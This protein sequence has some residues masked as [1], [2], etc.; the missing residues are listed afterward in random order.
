MAALAASS[1]THHLISLLD[2]LELE[3][4]AADELLPVL[5]DLLQEV[6]KLGTAFDDWSG[7]ASCLKWQAKLREMNAK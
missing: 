6:D 2:M 5:E 1:I 4:T 3:L 7:K